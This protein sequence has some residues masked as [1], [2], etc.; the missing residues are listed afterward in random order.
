MRK[1]TNSGVPL[2]KRL[3]W[4]DVRYFLAL[5]REG[6]LSRAA[7]VLGVEHSTVARRVDALELTLGLR[8]FDRLPRGW[9]LT[10]EGDAL[11]VQAAR[12]DDEAQAFA[13]VAVGASAIEGTVRISA[14]PVLAS[15]MLVP[16][17]ARR[18][19]EWSKIHLEV[20][21]ETREANL[22]RGEADL[23]VRMSRPTAPGLVVRQVGRMPFGLYGAPVWRTRPEADWLF[24]GFD[25][26]L[27]DVPQQRWLKGIA[28]DRPFIFRS[29]D[30][31]A[32]L[33]AAQAGLG[34]AALPTAIAAAAP[35][36]V[37]LRRD[38]DSPHRPIWL[39]MHPDVRRAP[40]VRLI[41]DL[42]A[43]VLNDA[44]GDQP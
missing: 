34:I 41:A 7:R 6:S 10:A 25:D 2:A 17:L 42:I 28:R 16:R 15:H 40:R 44:L 13:R 43:V 32:L 24:L 21:G 12:L 19:E 37:E 26:G 22:A 14:P 3:Q 8:L 18:R 30:L 39:V 36:L 5:S 33:H 31:S 35:D 9:V 27:G 4:D 38:A 11:A 29:N 1:S 23:A 20:I